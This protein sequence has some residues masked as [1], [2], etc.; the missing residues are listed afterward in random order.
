MQQKCSKT[1]NFF[2]DIDEGPS[3]KVS[4]F[5]QEVIIENFGYKIFNYL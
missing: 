5:V 4:P 1:N 2:E 3:Q